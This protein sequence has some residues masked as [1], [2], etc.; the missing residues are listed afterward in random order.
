MRTVETLVYCPDCLTFKDGVFT[1]QALNHLG[2]KSFNWAPS[3]GLLLVGEATHKTM[4][5]FSDSS[6]QQLVNRELR[7]PVPRAQYRTTLRKLQ[8]PEL[9]RGIITGLVFPYFIS[10][11]LLLC[12][13]FS[14]VSLSVLSAPKP[15]S[16]LLRLL[17]KAYNSKWW[18]TRIFHCWSK[19]LCKS[20]NYYRSRLL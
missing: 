12:C 7:G 1:S 2:S 4:F 3:Q 10:V 11:S 17:R 15:P 9:A 14:W 19:Q 6:S 8:A 5:P 18:M 16:L 20:F 13:Y